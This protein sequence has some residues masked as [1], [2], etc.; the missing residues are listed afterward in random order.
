[1]TPDQAYQAAMTQFADCLS[2]A[3]DAWNGAVGTCGYEA[4]YAYGLNASIQTVDAWQ[5][6]AGLGWAVALVAWLVVAYL[7]LK[8]SR[9]PR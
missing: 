5:F 4:G 1:M 8:L 6:V 7:A 9:R 2:R 3:G